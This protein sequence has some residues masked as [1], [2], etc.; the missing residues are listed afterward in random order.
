M[1]SNKIQW[2]GQ[3][4]RYFRH[5][6]NYTQLAFAK[7]M[8]VT[9]P[10]LSRWEND[11]VKIS[12]FYQRTLNKKLIQFAGRGYLNRGDLERLNDRGINL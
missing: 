7:M 11:G 3:K 10:Q 2:T 9:Q 1:K 4:L 8:E 12:R 6:I 5:R